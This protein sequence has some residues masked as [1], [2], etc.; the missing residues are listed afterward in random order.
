MCGSLASAGFLLSNR[1]MDVKVSRKPPNIILCMADDQGWHE[2]GYYDHPFLKTPVMDEMAAKGL[3]FDRFYSGAP[4]CSP[5]RAS[6]MTGRNPNRCGCFSWNYSIRPEE[7]T[8]AELVKESGYVTGHF[9]KWHLGPAKGSSF[10]NPGANGFDEWL[11]H[12][13]FFE[14]NPTL[15][16]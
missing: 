11:S 9:G 12:D 16:R 15:S 10:T 2:T 14:L 1:G 13:N 5:T 6:V 8:I 4:V 3:R 7:I